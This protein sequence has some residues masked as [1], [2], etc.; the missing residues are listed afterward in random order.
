MPEQQVYDILTAMF[1][2]LA[3]VQEVHPEAAKLS[4]ETAATGSSIPFHP[5]AIRFY[6]ERG[7]W[8]P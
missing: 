4:L 1:D 2:N 6:T 5:G 7:V 8:Q 3:E